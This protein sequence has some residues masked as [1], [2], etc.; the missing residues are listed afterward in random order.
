MASS[1]S[2]ATHPRNP[3]VD[4]AH[5][6]DDHDAKQGHARVSSARTDRKKYTL[7]PLPHHC[8]PCDCAERNAGRQQRGNHSVYFSL[9]SLVEV[10][11]NRHIIFS[12]C[13]VPA[14]VRKG[15]HAPGHLARV[16]LP[17]QAAK[18]ARGGRGGGGSPSA[19]GDAGTP[20]ATPGLARFSSCPAMAPRRAL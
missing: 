5:P 1:G 18:K 17:Q 14:R 13:I 3:E 15:A 20:V 10:L 12:P 11:G 2:R 8:R 7:L 9:I 6:P 16:L 4:G 19:E